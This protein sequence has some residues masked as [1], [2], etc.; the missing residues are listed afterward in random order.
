MND[1]RRGVFKQVLNFF[2]DSLNYYV[3]QN[4]YLNDAKEILTWFWKKS[5]ESTIQN[6]LPHANALFKKNWT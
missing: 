5:I 6:A 3:R 2:A 1:R 4:V